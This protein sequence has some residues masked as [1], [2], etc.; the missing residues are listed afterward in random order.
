MSVVL[1]GA[2]IIWL[3]IGVLTYLILLALVPVLWR[4]VMDPR[5]VAHLDGDVSLANLSP[6]KRQRIID[7]R[8]EFRLVTGLC[9]F[10]EDGSLNTDDTTRCTYGPLSVLWLCLRHDSWRR[11]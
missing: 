5:V 10:V 2:L 1:F 6:R 9:T 7:A 8:L 3:G 11:T 4:Q